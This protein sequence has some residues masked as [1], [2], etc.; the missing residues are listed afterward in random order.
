MNWKLALG[1]ALP[2][3]AMA[4]FAVPPAFL[5]FAYPALFS[6]AIYGLYAAARLRPEFKKKVNKMYLLK[7]GGQMVIETFDQT[8]HKV[9]ILDNHE[10]SFEEAKDGSLIFVMVNNGRP[11]KLACKDAELI[12]YD[13]TDRIVKAITIE[14]GRS[15]Q[16][17]HHLISRPTPMNL[18]PYSCTH[19]KP[20]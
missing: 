1:S 17:Y 20:V 10:N 9:N 4:V 14:T 3:A 8:L 5:P 18:R 13:L 12:D 2:A 19:Y 15:Q 7:N 11:F 6:P 16:F